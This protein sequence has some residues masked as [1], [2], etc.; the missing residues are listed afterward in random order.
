MTHANC[1]RLEPDRTG[2]NWLSEPYLLPKQIIFFGN[3]AAKNIKK[4][5]TQRRW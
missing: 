3:I 2:S 1:T 5:N 4:N